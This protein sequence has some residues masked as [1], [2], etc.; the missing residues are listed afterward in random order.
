MRVAS[1]DI[2]S[3]TILLL[4]AEISKSGSLKPLLDEQSFARI[5]KDVFTTGLIDSEALGRARPILERY[6]ARIQELTVD[7]ILVTGTSPFRE[8][9]NGAEFAE[10]ISSEFG[11]SIDVLSGEEEARLTY[12]GAISGV[13]PRDLGGEFCVI[14]IGGGSTEISIGDRMKIHTTMSLPVGAVRITQSFLTNSEGQESVGWR[15]AVENIDFNLDAVALPEI[16]SCIGVAGTIT[17]LACLFRRLPTFEIEKIDGTVLEKSTV[18]DLL[19]YLA[20]RSAEELRTIPCIS[21]GREDI[22]VGGALILS[23]F[24]ERTKTNQITASVRGLRYG[25]ALRAAGVL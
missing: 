2:G 14:D 23:R 21:R 25:T 8:A 10:Q 16:S 12:V 9:V 20:G 1:I 7:S 15:S 22:I 3:N 13:Q 19:T 11:F 17:T 6:K 4:I 18:Y 24:L 5:G